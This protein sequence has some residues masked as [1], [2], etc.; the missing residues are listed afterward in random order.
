MD[1]CVTPCGRDGM[2][3]VEFGSAVEEALLDTAAGGCWPAAA[4]ADVCATVDENPTRSFHGRLEGTDFRAIGRRVFYEDAPIVSSAVFKIEDGGRF[5]SR[6]YL[7]NKMFE[8]II[9]RDLQDVV[10]SGFVFNLPFEFDG[11][12]DGVVSRDIL[13]EAEPIDEF[14]VVGL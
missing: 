10:D 13:L 3:A 11:T 1:E 6:K 7:P 14:V 4:V 5:T 12:R 9:R 2:V 8:R